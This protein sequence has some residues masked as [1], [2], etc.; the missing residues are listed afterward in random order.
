MSGT[1]LG[2]SHSNGSWTSSMYRM[3]CHTKVLLIIF[4]LLNNEDTICYPAK[5]PSSVYTLHVYSKVVYCSTFHL[6]TQEQRVRNKNSCDDKWKVP[7]NYNPQALQA[8]DHS[9]IPKTTFKTK[10]SLCS[11]SLGQSVYKSSIY[12][13]SYDTGDHCILTLQQPQDFCLQVALSKT[14]VVVNM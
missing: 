5:L 9:E 8:L 13:L 11:I 6:L 4:P 10:V 3:H 7:M 14:H 12:L 1:R 2:Q